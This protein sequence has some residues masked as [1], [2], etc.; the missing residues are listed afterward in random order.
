MTK[1]KELLEKSVDALIENAENCSELAQA[2]RATADK[3]HE[4]AH[5]LAKVSKALVE[6]AADIKDEMEAEKPA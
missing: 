5:K 6:R 4:T 1:D 2:Q 3:Q